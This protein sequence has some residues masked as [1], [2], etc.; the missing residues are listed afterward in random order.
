MK[1][2]LLISGGLCVAAL[3]M[4]RFI[5]SGEVLGTQSTQISVKVV[6][7]GMSTQM[8]GIKSEYLTLP[9]PAYLND[10]LS[11]IKQNHANFAPMLPR[12]QVIVNGVPTADNPR[13][14]N[15]TEVDL[16]PMY[17]GG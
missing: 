4:Q 8:G 6:Y 9:S 5:S 11:L 17:P 14:S 10:V 7:L 12:M 15:D 1:K 3:G 2:M 16:L 13:L